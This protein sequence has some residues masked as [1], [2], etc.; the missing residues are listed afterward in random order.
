VRRLSAAVTTLLGL[1]CLG[2]AAVAFTTGPLPLGHLDAAVPLLRLDLGLDPLAAPFLGLL[3]VL[4]I[5]VGLGERR[6]EYGWPLAAF[7]AAM[8]CVL[9][10]RSVA[11]FVL[12]WE[13]MAL[14]SLLL[15]AA[16]VELRTVR[17][18][19][20]AYVIV[21]Q[22]GALTILAALMLLAAHAGD[23]S[24]AALARAAHDQGGAWRD[25]AIALAL[26]GF[27]SKAGLFPLHF[28]LPR[29]HP[30]A[31]A[32]ASALLSG[33]M[34]AIALYGIVLL[35]F[36]LAAPVAPVWGVVLVAVGAVSAVGGILYAAVDDDLKRLLAFSSIEHVGIVTIGIGAAILFTRS[37]PPLAAT[38]LGAALF[39]AVNHGLFKSALFL[40]AGR[41]AKREGTVDLNQLGGL[42]RGL[43]WT[44]S[45]M[46]VA[47]LGIAALP[48]LN[49]FASE[50]LLLRG[51]AD[52]L[53]VGDATART[54]A[55]AAI[56]ALVLAGGLALA[57]FAKVC[58][59]ALFGAARHGAGASGA[60]ERF[61]AGSGALA[62]LA[63]LC[64]AIGAFPQL[65][66]APL[67]QLGAQL[68]GVAPPD[69]A[70][71]RI[72]AVALLPLAGGALALVLA[73]V[74]G[75]RFA[76]TWSCGSLPG[77]AAQYSATAFS[78]PLRRIFAFVL[79]P[80][81]EKRVD[82]GPSPWF[83][84]AIRYRTTTTHVLDRTIRWIGARVLLLSR[85]GRRVQSRSL[86]LY[87]AYAAIVLVVVV[88]VAR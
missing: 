60:P 66:L 77:A 27:G 48:P 35:C 39:H 82:A 10:A 42:A 49:G 29:A 33:A 63:A 88:A 79:L 84:R 21:S 47:I 30:V 65:V 18:A 50:W 70:A 7:V 16:H 14:A 36:V 78:K 55:L 61:D 85:L 57:C 20:F 72:P 31:P 3:G 75:V 73:R 41:I 9:T 67:A 52:G 44:S 80:Q 83:P 56:V 34:L 86:R 81:V 5:A 23:A 45:A 43:P 59:I 15:V 37:Q 19:A 24:F 54:S 22:A 6:Q 71:A 38:L 11:A 87:L 12:A 28:W 13:A 4:A 64:I 46:L 58:G 8:A 32:P 25:V 69:V 2:A 51:L 76:P 53:T 62:G 17:R 26:F 40:G 1:L 68:I 74:R